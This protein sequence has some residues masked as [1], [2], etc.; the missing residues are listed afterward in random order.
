MMI[1]AALVGAIGLGGAMAYTYKT[2]VAPSGGRAPVIKAADSG[3]NKVKPE[4]PD[5]KVVPHTDKKL[6]NRLGEDGSAPPARVVV[7]PSQR[8]GRGG[9]Q[10]R[11]QRA[12]Q[13]QDH[14]HH[15]AGAPPATTASAPPRPRGRR[16]SLFP[17]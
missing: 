7:P 17:A 1:A 11:S 13:G 2:F 12:A 8:A 16:W 5:G 10:R 6:L 14:S 3:P 9:R 15:A 4:V